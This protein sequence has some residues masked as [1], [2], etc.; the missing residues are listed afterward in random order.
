MENQLNH[1]ETLT[2][3]PTL[4]FFGLLESVTEQQSTKERLAEL[5]TVFD[6]LMESSY[7]GVP[8]VMKIEG[9]LPGPTVAVMAVTH[10]NEPVGLSTMKYILD[11]IAPHPDQL[12]GSIL[13]VVNNLEAAEMYFNAETEDEKNQARFKDVDINRIPDGAIDDPTDTR[14]EIVR[15]RA[16]RQ[17]LSDVD[18]VLDMHSTT[19]ASTPMIISLG[20]SLDMGLVRGMPIETIISNI[21]S[22]QIGKPSISYYGS[23]NPS[24]RR[25]GIET[26]S[27]EDPATFVRAV[28]CTQALFQNLKMIQGEEPQTVPAYKEYVVTG[29]VIFPDE[30]FELVKLFA[31]FEEIRKED[32]IAIGSGGH[33]IRAEA[34]GHILFAARKKP[35]LKD[36]GQEV[37]FFT[38]PVRVHQ[39]H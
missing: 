2:R 3:K 19:Q 10:G 11:E 13:L 26:G 21:E 30:S 34:D 12:A 8:G 5:R 25:L 27:H 32:V 37:A 9:D 14:P 28:A 29:S 4:G 24:V 31:N 20:D 15:V 1:L 18:V 17:A 38:A 39:A 22:V 16:L 6:R 7:N 23:G 33:T 36:L 35:Y